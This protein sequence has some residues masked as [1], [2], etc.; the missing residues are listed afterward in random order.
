VQNLKIA[1]WFLVLLLVI[2]IMHNLWQKVCLAR[3]GERFQFL[4]TRLRF[5]EEVTWKDVRYSFLVVLDSAVLVLIL[6]WLT[7]ELL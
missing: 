7:E 2:R 3:T 4:L 1:I 5:E 6:V